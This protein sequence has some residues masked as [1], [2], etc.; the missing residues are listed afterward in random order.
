MP[1]EEPETLPPEVDRTGDDELDVLPGDEIPGEETLDGAPDE[2]PEVE[3]AGDGELDEAPGDVTLDGDVPL[4]EVRRVGEPGEPGEPEGIPDIPAGVPVGVPEDTPDDR[5]VA[6]LVLREPLVRPSPPVDVMP[7]RSAS[8][9]A[10]ETAP[11]TAETIFWPAS[12]GC[13][14]ETRR[15]ASEVATSAIRETLWATSCPLCFACSSR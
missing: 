3:R 8:R 13:S 15:V 12:P 5:P 1:G 7:C 4:D 9:R 10:A 14:P 6:P 2:L 11:S